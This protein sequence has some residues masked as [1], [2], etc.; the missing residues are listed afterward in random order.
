[1]QRV[2]LLP[3]G[4]G[5]P[6]GLAVSAVSRAGRAAG[7]S[8]HHLDRDAATGAVLGFQR[9]DHVDLVELTSVGGCRRVDA[10]ANVLLTDLAEDVVPM[11]EEPFLVSP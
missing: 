2:R 5:F 8:A 3:P 9:Q 11:L 7:G 1:M 6:G 10:V 4:S